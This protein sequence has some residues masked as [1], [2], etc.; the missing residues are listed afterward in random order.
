MCRMELW[1]RKG[2]QSN[3]GNWQKKFWDVFSRK[4]KRIS[5]YQTYQACFRVVSSPP[6]WQQSKY[7]IV[8]FFLF[9]FVRFSHFYIMLLVFS[10]TFFLFL[11]KIEFFWI[12]VTLVTVLHLFFLLLEPT[13]TTICIQTVSIARKD[14]KLWFV[15]DFRCHF[16]LH[17]ALHN[18]YSTT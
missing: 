1:E 4:L 9:F 10:I 12:I 16:K 11:D 15:T 7:E 5:K 17:L 6:L 13:L 3:R 14:W 18:F 2:N 8:R